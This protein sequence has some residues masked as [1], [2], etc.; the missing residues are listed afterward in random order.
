MGLVHDCAVHRRDTYCIHRLEVRG[1]GTGLLRRVLYTVYTIN[2]NGHVITA[3]V[4]SLCQI[5]Q[6]CR[7]CQLC[8]FRQLCQMCHVCQLCQLCHMCHRRAVPP[9][10]FAMR[11]GQMT[12]ASA[13]PVIASDATCASRASWSA[14]RDRC[15]VL[16]MTN[17]DPQHVETCAPVHSSS[18]FQTRL[19]KHEI[20]QTQCI[21]LNPW[22]GLAS[23]FQIVSNRTKSKVMRI[24]SR[25]KRPTQKLLSPTGYFCR[26]NVLYLIS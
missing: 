2:G 25:G 1:A 3:D 19:D 16:Q 9:A 20:Q 21:I 11:S 6:L 10:P 14:C 4:P 26:V 18:S 15:A 22:L 7:L 23:P 17:T 24:T 13:L 12:A 8:K 5:L